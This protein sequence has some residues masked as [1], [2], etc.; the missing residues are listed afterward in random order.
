MMRRENIWVKEERE[1]MKTRR[2][3]IRSRGERK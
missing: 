3:K 1:N 2:E